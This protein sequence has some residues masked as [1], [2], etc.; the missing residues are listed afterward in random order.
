MSCIFI[1]FHV[2]GLKATPTT[3][4]GEEHALVKPFG[5]CGARKGL[6][7]QSCRSLAVFFLPG[8]RVWSLEPWLT[9]MSCLVLYP[10]LQGIDIDRGEARSGPSGEAEINPYLLGETNPIPLGSGEAESIP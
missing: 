5:L 8:R 7:H 3:L 9:R 6:K 4:Q 10:S 1:G 2:P